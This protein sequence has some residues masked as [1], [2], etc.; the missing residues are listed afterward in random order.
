MRFHGNF[1]LDADDG[2]HMTGRFGGAL[3]RGTGPVAPSRRVVLW[4]L[5]R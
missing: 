5:G 3:S 1:V 4:N 2:V